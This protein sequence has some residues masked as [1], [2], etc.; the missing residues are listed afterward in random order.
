VVLDGQHWIDPVVTIFA[1][2]ILIEGIA[3]TIDETKFFER[4]GVRATGFQ[5]SM[6]PEK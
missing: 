1:W 3:R 5:S 4:V 6:L 2:Q